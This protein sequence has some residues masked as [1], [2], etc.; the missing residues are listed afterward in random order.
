V[1]NQG[2]AVE[3]NGAL[4]GRGSPQ[5]MGWGELVDAAGA[6]LGRGHLFVSPNAQTSAAVAHVDKP[7]EPG[8]D[9]WHGRLDSFRS[10]GPI[11]ELPSSYR[12]RLELPDEQS[13][14]GPRATGQELAV[15]V[16]GAQE[17]EPGKY[18]LELRSTDGVLPAALTEL[19]GEA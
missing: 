11:G 16:T 10:N 14:S 15:E 6:V 7:Q 19:G 4:A 9:A 18:A 1:T 5:D 13:A 2:T 17:L 3:D 12:L 8:D